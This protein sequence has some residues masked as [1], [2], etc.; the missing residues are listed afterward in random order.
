MEEIMV[1]ELLPLRYSFD[2][3]EP[4]IDTQTVEIHYTKH[5]ATYL[6]NL[7]IAIEKHPEFFEWSLEKL[8]S[9][10]DQIPEDIRTAVRN[11]GGGVYNHNIYW[12]SMAPGQSGDPVGKL[13]EAINLTFVSFTN[14][15]T[16]FEKS[17]LGRF[18]SGYC[19]ILHYRKTCSR[20][21]L[22]MFGNMLTI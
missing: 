12:A 18:G 21:L 3:L 13:A 15:K 7:N 4:I 19:W 17:A 14:F 22:W 2:A 8:I 20:F 10:L 1:F 11:S 9:N 5:H 6:K 16:E